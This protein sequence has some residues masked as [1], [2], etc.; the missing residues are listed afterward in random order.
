[1]PNCRGVIMGKL[2]VALIGILAASAANAGD[3]N[4]DLSKFNLYS[5]YENPCPSL[6]ANGKFF[7]CKDGSISYLQPDNGNEVEGLCG[8]TAAANIIHQFC[9][10]PQD[11]EVLAKK[12]SDPTPGTMPITLNRG[13]DH[14]FNEYNGWAKRN[15]KA[16]LCPVNGSWKR[17]FYKSDGEFLLSVNAGLVQSKVL[18]RVRSNGSKVWRSP[19]AVVITSDGD[20]RQAHWV[21]VVDIENFTNP[22]KCAVSFNTGGEQFK[23]A[24]SQFRKMAKFSV[25]IWGLGSEV[26]VKFSNH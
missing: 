22:S 1:M 25:G 2:L 23:I 10:V 13:L 19:V 26:R 3:L 4:Y 9:N 21:T 12:I 24:C 18:Q 7:Y 14:I 5:Y 15:A 20:L 8:Q 17:E 16:P 11:V 6:S